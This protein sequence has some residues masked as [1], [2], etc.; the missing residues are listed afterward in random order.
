MVC[1]LRLFEITEWEPIKRGAVCFNSFKSR[2]SDKCQSCQFP[3]LYT[4]RSN[5][6]ALQFWREVNNLKTWKTSKG[7]FWYSSSRLQA[8]ARFAQWL[9]RPCLAPWSK[10]MLMWSITII[11][12]FAQTNPCSIVPVSSARLVTSSEDE[13]NRANEANP[14][15]RGIFTFIYVS[16]CKK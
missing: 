9:I 16:K 3:Y 7:V 1:N 14:L 5:Q 6:K 2:K 8:F 13:Q 10:A 11:I 12:T 15:W 4:K